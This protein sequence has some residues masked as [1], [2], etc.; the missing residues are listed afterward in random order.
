M[1]LYNANRVRTAT[2]EP[3]RSVAEGG[4]YRRRLKVFRG[5]VQHD[6]RRTAERSPTRGFHQS[7]SIKV[8]LAGWLLLVVATASLT[9]CGGG[10]GSGG[11]TGGGGGGGGG[12][13]TPSSLWNTMVWDSDIWG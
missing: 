7:A 5:L 3:G 1:F 2:A 13:G 10:S 4:G 12:G 9:G 8:R 6:P 11:G